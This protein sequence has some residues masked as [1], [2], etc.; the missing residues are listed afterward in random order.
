MELVRQAS[1]HP[2][3]EVPGRPAAPE[4]EL[5]DL[6]RDLKF[7]AQRCA[8][9]HGMRARFFDSFGKTISLV[10]FVAGA[11][12]FT[13]LIQGVGPLVSALATVTAF[14][15]GLNL[16]VGFARKGRDHEVLRSKYYGVM[17]ELEKA[18]GDGQR[19]REIQVRLLGFYADG[20]I[21]MSALDMIAF[22]RVCASTGRDDCLTYV[23]WWHRALAHVWSFTGYYCNGKRP[24]RKRGTGAA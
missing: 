8:Y 4:A 14:F 16:I 9:Y 24:A 12:A 18:R 1:D 10:S 6:Y 17:V 11:G 23:P 20:T 13:S 22:N 3:P 19:L 2:L 5:D 21:F 15:S 7:E